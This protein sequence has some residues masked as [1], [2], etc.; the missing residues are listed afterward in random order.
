[1]TILFIFFVANNFIDAFLSQIL[2]DE[3]VIFDLWV[4]LSHI[5]RWC[6][7]AKMAF[8][9]AV[10]VLDF[11]WALKTLK[12]QYPG[13][14]ESLIHQRK[15]VFIHVCQKFYIEVQNAPIEKSIAHCFFVFF[16][17]VDIS[18]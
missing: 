7:K 6:E 14:E 12:S 15:L 17:F 1:V 18:A 3:M 16:N 9:D 8:R 5:C 11:F 13:D 2:V 4:P 10:L